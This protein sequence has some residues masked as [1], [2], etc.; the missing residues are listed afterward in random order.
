MLDG[1][2]LVQTIVG[3]GIHAYSEPGADPLQ[4]PLE[5]PVDAK[6]GPDG[7]LYVLP[8]HEGRVIRL[9]ADVT[10]CA[11]TGVIGDA[12]DGGDAL[13]AEMGYGGGLALGPDGSMFIS[14]NTFSRVRRVTPDGRIDTILGI[15]EAGTGAPGPGPS[16]AIRN[17]E[18]VALDEAN[19]R[20][21]VADTGNH[22]V[23]AVDLG[24][25]RATVIAGTGE[26]GWAGDGGPGA[27]AL[28]DGPVGVEVV[29]GGV[30]VADLGNDVVRLVDESGDIDVV[31]GVVGGGE[32]WSD[33]PEAFAM[34]GPAGLA[35]T[36]D[37]D[38]LVAERTG[39]RVL[40]W[41]GARDAL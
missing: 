13:D 19:D 29:A 5:N 37:G 36:D 26:R 14:D 15:G 3:N 22:R 17:P 7:V 9:D 1:D 32:S 21:I 12:G 23:I 16:M 34:K 39:Q 38:L 30:L 18:R 4:T 35:W 20:L 24:T 10:V 33:V 41:T 28:L 8:Q 31:A 25:L 27:A 40:R 2:G 6:W 11:G